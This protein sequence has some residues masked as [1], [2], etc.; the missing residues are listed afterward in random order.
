MA[1]AIFLPNHAIAANER[2]QISLK[3][4]I[5]SKCGLSQMISDLPLGIGGDHAQTSSAALDFTIDCNAPFIYGLSS[6]N[7]ALT[8]RGGARGN[9]RL[10][11]N[12]LPYTIELTVQTND[13]GA[14]SSTCNSTELHSALSMTGACLIDSGQSIA[15]DQKGRIVLRWV[16][17]KPLLAG[18]YADGLSILINAKN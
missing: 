12:Q 4:Q 15:T 18:D 17:G 13:D 2:V 16:A 7:G 10:A 9:A 1:S 5:S 6:A 3:G 11:A 14:I 8:F